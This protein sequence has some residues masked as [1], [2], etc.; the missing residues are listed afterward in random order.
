MAA[1]AGNL[2]EIV[3]RARILGG[4]MPTL[5]PFQQLPFS[6]I[7]ALPTRPHPYFEA[8]A[9]EV[10]TTSRR[11]GALRIH[12]REAGSGPPLLLIHGLMTTSYS[13]RYMIEPLGRH[14]RLVMPDL[15]GCGRS[16]APPDGAYGPAALADWIGDLQ[17]S[18][19]IEGCAAIGN[20]MG[21]YLCLHRALA[22][23]GAFSRLVDI[24]SPAFPD[25]K[26]E[27][28]AALLRAPGTRALA[29]WLPGRS[30][31]RWAHRNV[32]YHDETLKSLEEAHEYGD[33]LA[34]REGARAFAA[35]LA[36]TMAPG[37][38]RALTGELALRKAWGEAFPVPL[39][40]L[41]AERDPLVSPSNGDRLKA[42]MPEATLVRV[43]NTSHFMHVD[44]P[45]R[46]VAEV[47]PFLQK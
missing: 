38:M 46:V 27:L 43:A 44:S 33:P 31:L 7:P 2:Q 35:Y 39:L 12:V 21:G 6:A 17:S 3:T 24:H 14:F 29:A 22:H 8:A 41:Y 28:L 13:W 10:T 5:R 16:E 20:S 42:L 37:E 15:P 4:P 36:E 25:G 19:G 34:T 32:H 26:L 9:R 18:L 47:L 23:P 40:L 1:P 11:L 30:P 45:D